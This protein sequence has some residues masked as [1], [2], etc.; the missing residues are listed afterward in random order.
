MMEGDE[1]AGVAHVNGAPDTFSSQPLQPL[2]QAGLSSDYLAR[3][4]NRSQGMAGG[5]PISSGPSV[6]HSP[7]APSI[8]G[9][10]DRQPLAAT[11]FT[12]DRAYAPPMTADF[13]S[14]NDVD[15]KLEALQL[16]VS[17]FKTR[18]RADFDATF[19]SVERKSRTQRKEILAH[20]TASLEEVE[21][22]LAASLKS[23]LGDYQLLEIEFRRNL[24]SD[25][26]TLR[27]EMEAAI[28]NEEEMRTELARK[29][30]QQE[31]I[32]LELRQ[33]V[34][35][36]LLGR[37]SAGPGGFHSVDQQ[38]IAF[39]HSLD[40]LQTKFALDLI[41]H[42]KEGELKNVDLSH[43]IL[44]LRRIVDSLLTNEEAHQRS[45]AELILR[46][47]EKLAGE[48]QARVDESLANMNGLLKNLYKNLELST[49]NQDVLHAQL[50]ELQ[51]R[52]SGAGLP[53]AQRKVTQG[54][55]DAL[56]EKL[57]Q[58]VHGPS[59][60]ASSSEA[61]RSLQ[62]VTEVHSRKLESLQ[63]ASREASEEQELRLR[64]AVDKFKKDFSLSADARFSALTLDSEVLKRKLE[65][66][67]PEA[68]GKEEVE[69]K[70]HASEKESQAQWKQVREDAARD[71]LAT[72]DEA[73]AQREKQGQLER[74]MEDLTTMLA[75]LAGQVKSEAKSREDA[76]AR[77]KKLQAEL[78]QQKDQ[79]ASELAAMKKSNEAAVRN[80]REELLG[81]VQRASGKTEK[82]LVD[83]TSEVSSDLHSSSRRLDTELQALKT[84]VLD[85]ESQTRKNEQVMKLAEGM[86]M[87]SSQAKHDSGSTPAAAE[88]REL[89]Q[90]LA[91]LQLQV[92]LQ[93][94]QHDHLSRTVNDTISTQSTIQSTL[95]ALS[96]D[97][98]RSSA[99]QKQAEAEQ[100]KKQQNALRTMK[101]EVEET[102][103]ETESRLTRELHDCKL[104]LQDLEH[105]QKL[106]KKYTST[107]EAGG[108]AI[109]SPREQ[110]KGA[111]AEVQA[112]TAAKDATALRTLQLQVEELEFKSAQA[113]QNSA[114][115]RRANEDVVPRVDSLEREL[116]SVRS[117][118]M[119][120]EALVDEQL[121]SKADT[122]LL[123][124]FRREFTAQQQG[125]Q[126]ATLA[127]AQTAL[128]TAQQAKHAVS[129]A[130]VVAAL[131]SP[132][133]LF[134]GPSVLTPYDFRSSYSADDDEVGPAH[135]KNMARAAG[136]G[137]GRSSKV[138]RMGAVEAIGGGSA[139]SSSSTSSSRGNS[140][141]PRSVLRKAEGGGKSPTAA[142]SAGKSVHF[143]VQGR[144]PTSPSHS[145]DTSAAD[146]ESILPQLEK[147]DVI[148]KHF[149]HGPA[150]SKLLFYSPSPPI[151]ST[152]SYSLA[153][154]APGFLH[155][156]EPDDRARTVLPMTTLTVSR[157]TTLAAGKHTRAFQKPEV[158]SVPSSLCFS[159]LSADRTLEVQ[160]PSRF[161]RDAWIHGLQ[162][163][164]RKHGIKFVMMED[165]GEEEEE[166]EAN[167]EE[168]RAPASSSA[169]AST[170]GK[171]V[172]TDEDDFPVEEERTA[173]QEEDDDSSE[174]EPEIV[175]KLAPSTA[176]APSARSALFDRL[177]AGRTLAAN[178]AKERAAAKEREA[179]A[180]IEQAGGGRIGAAPPS[181]SK[182]V[183]QAKADLTR[184]QQLF[185]EE[186]KRTEAKRQADREAEAQ[187][188]RVKEQRRQ[189]E[190]KDLEEKLRIQEE[191]RVVALE[192]MKAAS[193]AKAQREKDAAAER[194]RAAQ[195]TKRAAEEYTRLAA[196]KRAQAEEAEEARRKEE[197]RRADDV[198]TQEALAQEHARVLAEKAKAIE[199]EKVRLAAEKEA[200]ETQIRLAKE[201]EEQ[202]ARDKQ[203]R[204]AQ[205]AAKA[206]ADKEAAAAAEKAANVAAAKI[207]A[208]RKVAAAAEA[209]KAE[210]EAAEKAKAAIAAAEADHRRQRELAS[211]AAPTSASS[212]MSDLPDSAHHSTILQESEEDEE[213]EEEEEDK[214]EWLRPTD[215]IIQLTLRAQNVPRL[216]NAKA[217][218]LVYHISESGAPASGSPSFYVLDRHHLHGLDEDELEEY[219]Q[220]HP[221]CLNGIFDLRFPLETVGKKKV[222]VRLYD[223]LKSSPTARMDNLVGEINDVDLTDLLRQSNGIQF[224]PHHPS[225]G[226]LSDRMKKN[227]T[228]VLLMGRMR[229]NLKERRAAGLP[230]PEVPQA[231]TAPS[232][233]PAAKSAAPAPAPSTAAPAVAAPVPARAT[234]TPSVSSHCNTLSD[235][236]TVRSEL[237]TY[238]L[239]RFQSD[240]VAAGWFVPPTAGGEDFTLSTADKPFNPFSR[241][242]SG[243]LAAPY[244]D[245]LAANQLLDESKLF[246]VACNRPELDAA[247]ASTDKEMVGRASM[248]QRHQFLLVRSLHWSTFNV[249]A[250]GIGGGAAELKSA[251]QLLDQMEATAR[252]YTQSAGWSKELGLFFH[253]FPF[254]S[255]NALH[256]HMVDMTVRGPTFEHLNHKNL[257]LHTVREQLIE[258][259]TKVDPAAAQK[260]AKPTTAAP[261]PAPAVNTTIG[262]DFDD[263]DDDL[264]LGFSPVAGSTTSAE[265]KP[266]SRA[267]TIAE[268]KAA[269]LAKRSA[270]AASSSTAPATAAA[271]SSSS[272]KPTASGSMMGGQSDEESSDADSDAE[273]ARQPAAR[274][275]AASSSSSSSSSSV[276]P[277]ASTHDEWDSISA[278]PAHSQA[279][280]AVV[281]MSAKK[282][283][284]ADSDD[285][286]SS[287]EEES[288]ARS[289]FAARS[290]LPPLGGAGSR[291]GATS[292]SR[293]GLA[294]SLLGKKPAGRPG[295]IGASSSVS[296]GAAGKLSSLGGAKKAPIGG[297]KI[298][299]SF[300]DEDDIE[301]DDF[302]E[303]GGTA[304]IASASSKPSAFAASA[305]KPSAAK[306]R[307]REDDSVDLEFTEGG[308]EFSLDDSQ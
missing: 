266:V 275:A 194:E 257:S 213:D 29:M 204:E 258:E 269:A 3:R 158:K 27:N 250:F 211:A 54:Q 22:R 207:E 251:V 308:D 199:T 30:K 73:R 190:L 113:L 236:S 16:M 273:P 224:L 7:R 265:K 173:S 195:E 177:Q 25:L 295:S 122:A 12:T 116:A 182:A 214:P 184:E 108:S 35:E 115:A 93:Q 253:C 260:L 229:R 212:S 156:V 200:K 130:H 287:D 299:M 185:A 100:E 187:L 160:A 285:D 217:T 97:L 179:T 21:S 198:A 32:S 89:Q 267:A 102:I 280:G 58:I 237:R 9:Y 242:V 271:P 170:V 278:S 144:E 132:S 147:G 191:E 26:Y 206:Q 249:A 69:R 293:G 209:V 232:V 83:R 234:F 241:L 279:S 226:E 254:N 8:G 202:A 120:H 159:V 240:M 77:E 104:K 246:M 263:D 70:L 101:A 14:S 274:P 109:G 225:K 31:S 17:S 126:A 157:I 48:M 47:G 53:A 268:A 57:I 165:D 106:A 176:S 44:D 1:P 169:S 221:D 255:V 205:A 19:T 222:R 151:S 96:R 286:V 41:G 298:G 305:V 131:N 28:R 252:Q 154:S 92:K 60:A 289:S 276:K 114:A 18:M 103:G 291:L 45:Q 245:L 118:A 86:A 107:G 133:P 119:Q 284:A 197:K 216:G 36:A 90:Q 215:V 39:Q 181:P 307:D 76:E 128:A 261:T 71:R 296:P 201:A 153:E 297:F 306:A 300:G 91:P 105:A 303:V 136:E 23:N 235:F 134:P 282:G 52:E 171:N 13:S 95:S 117:K 164:L 64:A 239:A 264:N 172:I 38:M 247:W 161:V 223:V 34:E 127:A 259:L 67:T 188:E 55:L 145:A 227:Q 230:D 63:Q 174:E 218:E 43:Q 15:Y 66:L 150:I 94:D 304:P 189:Q 180:Q 110:G 186:Q 302:V 166:E 123:D 262:G 233:A 270:A 50:G 152:A 193:A 148:L 24:K 99:A 146:F 141:S 37:G 210:A 139:V 111:V 228:Q 231:K 208:A 56:E 290:N 138:G 143:A 10:T 65:L 88:V 61:L 121:R 183:E 244:G 84:T 137:V 49:Q 4:F 292:S 68:L 220:E 243:K 142:S 149:S 40:A 256:L 124:K 219:T 11:G 51:A 98:D 283:A 85:V 75:T 20:V 288:G 294:S 203:A 42:K 163:L 6:M 167:G 155:W 78:A 87:A 248:A 62:N 277:V 46:N 5:V 82:L 74:R 175:A 135:R 2:S 140:L 196:A 81:E 72:S 168:E 301:E 33:K 129:Q 178:L 79:H 80:L 238:G 112:A 272:S 192:Q 125:Q 281:T 59:G 162:G